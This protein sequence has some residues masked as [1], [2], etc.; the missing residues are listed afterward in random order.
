MVRSERGR[1]ET[2]ALA[3]PE[4]MRGGSDREQG[5]E[6]D[7]EIERQGGSHGGKGGQRMKLS[8]GVPRGGV[9]GWLKLKKRQEEDRTRFLTVSLAKEDTG[10]LGGKRRARSKNERV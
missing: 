7:K 6:R 2:K 10:K 3:R 9:R 4:R 8:R 1:E 5:M